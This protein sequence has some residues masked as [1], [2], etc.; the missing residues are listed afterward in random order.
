MKRKEKKSGGEK[1]VANERRTRGEK[2]TGMNGNF[3]SYRR[4]E[5]LDV[6]GGGRWKNGSS[7]SME[8]F[9]SFF[10]FFWFLSSMGYTIVERQQQH[11]IHSSRSH[12]SLSAHHC[13][14]SLA[15]SSV[16]LFFFFLIFFLLL[17]KKVLLFFF[18]F[19]RA[20]INGQ[21]YLFFSFSFW[22]NLL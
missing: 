6:V 16:T 2:H 22:G 9:F 14:A 1:G 11:T 15:A 18:F 4:E 5:D 20:I 12:P 17:K 21:K 13:L 7:D 8:H 19:S 3:E 10:C